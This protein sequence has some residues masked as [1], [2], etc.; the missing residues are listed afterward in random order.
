MIILFTIHCSPNHGIDKKRT[1]RCYS[2]SSRYVKKTDYF[3]I[4]IF[5]V[6]VPVALVTL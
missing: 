6:N 3:W 1:T 2:G 4:T 5:L